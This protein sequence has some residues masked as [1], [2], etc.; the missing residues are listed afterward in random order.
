MATFPL[1]NILIKDGKLAAIIDLGGLGVGDPACDMVIAW[2]FL[3]GKSRE[4]FKQHVNLD[5]A[6]WERAKGWTLWKA[7]FELC[8]LIDKTSFEATK[9]KLI[10]AEILNR[11]IAKV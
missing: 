11:P 9:H 8:N 2:T 3:K 7:T 6:T 5:A 1:A 4:I 10:I